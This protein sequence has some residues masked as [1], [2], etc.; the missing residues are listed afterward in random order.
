MTSRLW[1]AKVSDDHFNRGSPE[2]GTGQG[3]VL[4]FLAGHVTP[5]NKDGRGAVSFEVSRGGRVSQIPFHPDP[6]FAIGL[7]DR[8]SDVLAGRRRM[9]ASLERKHLDGRFRCHV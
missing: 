3:L 2:S 5:C 9:G 4:G 6:L 8:S 1:S 7:F